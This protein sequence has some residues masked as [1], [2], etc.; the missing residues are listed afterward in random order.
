ME[1]QGF[2]KEGV[3]CSAGA[4]KWMIRQSWKSSEQA[5]QWLLDHNFTIAVTALPHQAQKSEALFLT[6]AQKKRLCSYQRLVIVM[7]HEK[8][9]VSPVFYQKA[10][11]VISYPMVGFVE[12]YNISVAV[13]LMASFFFQG[14]SF[15]SS[16]L[17]AQKLAALYVTQS[18]SSW[19]AL[20]S[21]L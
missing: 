4:E 20:L 15:S 21:R 16:S 6:E 14:R 2:S 1:P 3:R 8:Q 19:E 11:L 5:C 13:A 10:H 18:L 17:L 7:G 9:G 12:S